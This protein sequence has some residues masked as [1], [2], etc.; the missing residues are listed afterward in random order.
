MKLLIIKL[1]LTPQVIFLPR[2][3]WQVLWIAAADMIS[4]DF[5]ISSAFSVSNDFFLFPQNNTEE[6]MGKTCQ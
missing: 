4:S 3:I 6:D 2:F 5:D 1:Q